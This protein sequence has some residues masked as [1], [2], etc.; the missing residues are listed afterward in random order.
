MNARPARYMLGATACLA[1]NDAAIKALTGRMPTGELLALRGFVAAALL[2]AVWGLRR[3]PPDTHPVDR[4]RAAWEDGALRW[5]CAMEAGAAACAV[6]ALQRAPLASVTAIVQC[7]PLLTVLASLMLRWEPWYVGRLLPV[8]LGLGGAVAIAFGT[9]GEGATAAGWLAAA[10][11]ALAL[12]I[13]DLL[14]RC[15]SPE[16]DAMSA[17]CLGAALTALVG[18]GWG[19]SEDWRRPTIGDAC[20]VVGAAGASAAGTVLLIHAAREAL[21]S[22]LAPLRYSLMVWSALLA[23]LGW[24]EVPSAQELAGMAVIV[25]GGV[26]ALRAPVRR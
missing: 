16:T 22:T 24:D 26:L 13:R 4:A 11:C 12:G 21:P 10:G 1:L 23:Y 2:L 15:L 18:V 19:W 5:R 14:S 9:A 20:F 3:R 8:L 6:L 17:A 25:A 7:A